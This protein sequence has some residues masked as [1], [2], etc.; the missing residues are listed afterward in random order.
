MK[1]YLQ[2]FFDVVSQEIQHL[3]TRW[4]ILTI[5]V[6]IMLVLRALGAQGLADV[7]GLIY[8]MY[9]VTFWRSQ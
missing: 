2:T 8:I 3:E 6:L 7:T 1:T 4:L 5:T 9:F